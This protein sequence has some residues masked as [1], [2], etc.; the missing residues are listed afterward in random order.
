MLGDNQNSVRDV[1]N[2]SGTLQEHFAYSPF[3]QQVAAQSSN[4][5]SVSFAFG[6]TGTYTD[7]I[8]GLQLHGVR[9]YDPASQHWLSQDPSGLGPDS[10]PYRYCDN[11]PAGG[12]DPEGLGDTNGFLSGP[13][14]GHTLAD[15]MGSSQPAPQPAAPAFQFATTKGPTW[16]TERQVDAPG[17]EA[18]SGYLS[19]EF[20]LQARPR[21]AAFKDSNGRITATQVGFV[22]IARKTLVLYED[23]S[24]DAGSLFLSR[25][26][27][28]YAQWGSNGYALWG[29]GWFLDQ[30]SH[31]S[32]PGPQYSDAAQTSTKSVS[33]SSKYGGWC[34]LTDTP[35]NANYSYWGRAIKVLSIEGETHLICLAGQDKG[36]VYAG[37]NWSVSWVGKKP[38]ILTRTNYQFDPEMRP[39][40]TVSDEF[41]RIV[42]PELGVPLF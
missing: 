9:W 35:G 34:S 6:Y 37:W 15:M 13:A 10:N 2:D 38:D 3:G 20:T 12:T 42:E 14:P 21:T 25:A 11:A 40:T 33:A 27:R 32:V 28:G 17:D 22:Q 1:V 18:T 26:L 16:L 31:R 41:K 5:G 24:L 7:P 8:T 23:L 39:T 19:A 29:S 36:K 30:A 4:P